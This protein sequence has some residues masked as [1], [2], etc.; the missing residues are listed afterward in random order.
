MARNVEM[1]NFGL[2]MF[3]HGGIGLSLLFN[4]Q[5]KPR[6]NAVF[7]SVEGKCYCRSKIEAPL[8]DDRPSELVNAY[9][10]K[11]PSACVPIKATLATPVHPIPHEVPVPVSAKLLSRF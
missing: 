7:N 4:G 5:K 1:T 8:A 2:K 6:F 9:E 3:I 10:V 11:A